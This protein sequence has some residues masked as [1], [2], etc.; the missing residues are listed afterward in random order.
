MA[1]A[2][3]RLTPLKERMVGYLETVGASQVIFEG[4]FD[5]ATKVAVELLYSNKDFLQVDITKIG[6]TVMA[7]K[8]VGKVTSQGVFKYGLGGALIFVGLAVAGVM[9]YNSSKN[10]APEDEYKVKL[11]KKGTLQ[12]TLIFNE[13]YVNKATEDYKKLG[14]VVRVAKIKTMAEGGNIAVENAQIGK[15]YWKKNHKNKWT[16]YVFRG[17]DDSGN[18]LLETTETLYGIPKGSDYVLGKTFLYLNEPKHIKNSVYHLANGGGVMSNEEWQKHIKPIIENLNKLL[19][20]GSISFEQY[21]YSISNLQ[22]P[23]G[24][25]KGGSVITYK[26]KYNKKYGYEKNES[27]SL[28]DIAKDTK[29]SIKGLQQIYDKGI[30]AYKTNP[31]SVRPNVKSKEQWA[32]AR[33]YSSVMGGK[34]SKIDANELKMKEGGKINY[35]SPKVNMSDISFIHET[36]KE[37]ADKILKEGFIVSKNE[38]ITKGVYTIPIVYKKESFNSQE[39]E[40]EVFLKPNS[41]IFWTNTKRP[42]DFYYGVGNNFFNAL[43][44]KLGGN[45]RDNNRIVFLR[46]MEK[47]LS[48]NGYCGIQQGGEIVITDLSCIESIQQFERHN[49]DIHIRYK[50]GGKVDANELKMA[51]GGGV[52]E[53]IKQKMS[54]MNIALNTKTGQV[55]VGGIKPKNRVFKDEKGYYLV[56]GYGKFM[57]KKYP[58]KKHFTPS[59]NEVLDA[60]MQDKYAKGG[61]VKTEFDKG[62]VLNNLDMIKEYSV[63]IDKMVTENTKLDE[64]IKMKL[65]KVEQNMADIKHAIEG[66]DKYGE[67]GRIFKKQLL[68]ISKYASDIKKMVSGKKEVMS[69]IE[70]KLFVSADYMD[71]LYH[72]L[73]YESGNTASK[74]KKGGKV[75]AEYVVYDWDTYEKL[76]THKNIESAKRNMYELYKNKRNLHLAIKNRAEFEETKEMLL[77]KYGGGI[78]AFEYTIGGL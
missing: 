60:Y 33:V 43:F 53:N 10:R 63:A 69:W 36:S 72:F 46:N 48:N 49:T 75:G 9:A 3:Y 26:N 17:K 44:I 59:E 24:Y 71:T 73:D 7:S 20:N 35:G 15:T 12:D 23:K 28:E 57:G 67:G 2:K 78:S 47:W 30:G 21:Q 14:Y 76:S 51:N 1:T 58:I 4:S 66:F 70:G 8:K 18:F 41:K 45:Q 39:I 77:M 38:N 16:E 61:G 56:E 32:M 62:M 5:E 25:S 52:M 68:H 27:H 22:N 64:W 42:M 11:Y 37:I 6:K 74:Y 50:A 31:Q 65:T 54:E 40:L 29:I 55:Y 13:S 19:E 34:A